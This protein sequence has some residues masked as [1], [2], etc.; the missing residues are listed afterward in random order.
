ME[1]SY[2]WNTLETFG[3]HKD[4]LS[5]LKIIYSDIESV[6]KI[7]GGLC[8]P[9]KVSRGIRQGCSLSG[10][11]YSIAIEPLLPKIWKRLNGLRVPHCDF[12]FCLS[13][14]ADYV[15]IMINKQEDIHVL[16]KLIE[17]FEKMVF[18]KG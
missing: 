12:N 10:M 18:R 7:N 17:S 4:F 13:A 6:I 9:F 16:S 2:L 3:F 1:H 5:M 11:L 15:I 14:Y 8:A